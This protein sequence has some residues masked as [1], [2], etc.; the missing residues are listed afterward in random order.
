[1]SLKYRPFAAIGITVLIT[2]FLIIFTS[3][4][5]APIALCGGALACLISLL[6]RSLRER[7]VPLY[8]AG[9]VL[10]SGLIYYAAT[11]D[12]RKVEPYIG[13]TA[14]VSGIVTDS[15]TYS[16]YRY[17]YILDLEEINGNSVNSKLRLSLPN[18]IAVEPFDKVKLDVN[19]YEISAESRDVKLYYYS[20]GVF[21]GGYIY[22]SEDYVV[23]I[24]KSDQHIIR[25]SILEFKN[26]IVSNVSDNVPGE[27]GATISAM[28]LGDK[29]GLSDERTESF[30][31]VGIAPIF[32]V[33]GLHLSI[34]VMGLFS[35]L[36][37]FGLKKRVNSIISIIFTVFFMILTGLT[38]SVCRSGI[39][40][41][42]LLVGNVFYRKVDS[43]NSLG[44]VA[45]IL[46]SLNPYIAVDTGFILS[47][48]ATLGIVTLVPLFEK[49]VLSELPDNWF[50]NYL[51][52]IVLPIA[53]SVSASI[54]VLPF[55]ILMIGQVSVLSVLT[56]VLLSYIATICMVT[57]GLAS[58]VC[59]V[60]FVSD[61]LFSISGFLSK[62]ILTVVDIFKVF[63]ITQISTENLFW[64]VGAILAIAVVIFAVANFRGKSIFKF[65]CIGLAADILCFSL[66]SYFYFDGLTQ[67]RILNVGNGIS[68]VAYSDGE[69]IALT[70]EADEYAKRYRIKENLEFYN[71]NS[72][73]LLLLADK[74]A[75]NDHSNFN[76]IKSI[77][78]KRI[79]VP[80]ADQSI[81]R[82]VSPDKLFV[83][84]RAA[85]DVF[86]DDR[87]R[88]ETCD[89][90]SLALCNF[91]GISIL[92]LFDSFKKAEIPEEYLEADILVC[93]G[94]IP[95]CIS[96]EIYQKVI[97]C[98]D[99]EEINSV[100]EYVTECGGH[101]LPM[102]D[103]ESVLVDIRTDDQF[104]IT[105][106][107]G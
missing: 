107:E 28:L 2:L 81:E 86:N 25:K 79:V 80:Y 94:F 56:N 3:D 104:K 89:S 11:S 71:N 87:I 103:C 68:V 69:K 5:F 10:F 91:D 75:L 18:E 93:C 37:S 95:Y 14:S 30:R 22:N 43:V 40:M 48:S 21:L 106:L 16:N 102:D 100:I 19:I 62:F 41:I 26:K 46:C 44:F 54:A 35:L 77:D 65:I 55:T 74:N 58:T 76:I 52:S 45:F 90:Y 49:K 7:L 88:Y 31:E 96:P 34:W 33:S 27:Q 73:D 29:S 9:A 97:V 63:P 39:M 20:K 1:M 64:K 38:P 59:N 13:K 92:F 24:E 47:F 72:S 53:V 82:L 6:F 57:G 32:A 84:S 67:I 99:G 61:I 105:V 8:I 78:F 101:A 15:P 85:I 17:Y 66:L 51:K 36:K 83:E 23:Q 12:I 98:G 70:G 42:M 50:I 4:K 60:P